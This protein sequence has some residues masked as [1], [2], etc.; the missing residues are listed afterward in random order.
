MYRPLTEITLTARFST[1]NYIATR[2]STV[3]VSTDRSIVNGQAC[4]FAEAPCFLALTAEAH[5]PTASYC[6]E[7]LSASLPH[8]PLQSLDPSLGL[9]NKTS[10]ISLI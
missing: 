6:W 7:H 1:S 9:E 3:K 2:L 10:L 4:Y 5:Q 8:P